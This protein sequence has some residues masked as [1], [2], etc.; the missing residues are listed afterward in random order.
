MR[1]RMP[2]LDVMHIV[3]GNQVQA[4]ILSPR[5]ELPIHLHLLRYAVIV[6][7]EIIVFRAERLLEPVDLILRLVKLLGNDQARNFAC[8]TAAQADQP[9]LVRFED[10]LINSRLVVIPLSLRERDQS[11]EILIADLVFRKEHQ[12]VIGILTPGTGFAFGAMIRGHINFT[13]D[14][15]LDVLGTGRPVKIDR[16]EHHP[17]VCDGDGLEI[18]LAGLAHQPVHTTGTVEQ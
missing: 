5:D 14:D 2:L 12:M 11:H 6:Q 16:A 17:V 10:L 9:F 1:M 4:K 13:A 18:H 15:R 7:L 8:E 3:G